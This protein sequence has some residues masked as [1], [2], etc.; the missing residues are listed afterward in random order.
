MG[1]T[2]RPI[3]KSQTPICREIRRFDVEHGGEVVLIHITRRLAEIPENWVVLRVPNNADRE[4]PV[5]LEPLRAL[6][7]LSEVDQRRHFPIV[8]PSPVGAGIV[9]RT[10]EAVPRSL[11]VAVD[12]AEVVEGY[13]RLGEKNE[14]LV[15]EIEQRVCQ[16]PPL[17]IAHAHLSPFCYLETRNI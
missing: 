16:E 17:R 12:Y 9:E 5:D 10:H 3:D 2:P 1:P 14:P 11:Q 8:P 6:A 7:P 15:G 13:A 4:P